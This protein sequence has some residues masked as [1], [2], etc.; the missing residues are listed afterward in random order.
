[1][2]RERYDAIVEHHFDQSR[3]SR[4]AFLSRALSEAR[5]SAYVAWH[6]R[7]EER[8][9][10][11]ARIVEY[12]LRLRIKR[13]WRRAEWQMDEGIAQW[14]MDLVT[15]IEFERSYRRESKKPHAYRQYG[16]HKLT[17]AAC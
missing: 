12:T 2:A 9:R 4:A 16:T 17:R 14:E 13:M 15:G 6:W 5:S 1:L 10:L 7:H 8:E 3:L 11:A